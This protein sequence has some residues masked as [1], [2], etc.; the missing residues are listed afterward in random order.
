MR[1][2]TAPNNGPDH[3][4][5]RLGNLGGERAVP[6][7]S[8]MS[9]RNADSA[10]P[11]TKPWMEGPVATPKCCPP[12][13]S[14]PTWVMCA[15]LRC[16]VRPDCPLPAPQQRASFSPLSALAWQSYQP[17]SQGFFIFRVEDIL[18]LSNHHHLAVSGRYLRFLQQGILWY[19]V[20]FRIGQREPPFVQAPGPIPDLEYMKALPRQMPI[21]AL[22]GGG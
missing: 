11:T 2:Q 20:Y 22:M 10:I 19:L 17:L 7:G 3:A 1:W 8:A 13:P 16:L 6:C 4:G 21:A 5:A 15:R 12:P 9:D 18:L 14:P